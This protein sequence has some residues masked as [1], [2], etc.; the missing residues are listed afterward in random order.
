[1]V[2]G[3]PLV[4]QANAEDMVRCRS[5]RLINVGMTAAEVRG[6]CGEPKDI[7]VEEVPVRAQGAR[8]QSTVIVGVTRNERWTIDRG[9]G[10]FAAV[11]SFESDKLVRID[12]L[13]SR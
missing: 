3:G 12:L 8:G 4:P 9:Q 11:L 2:L 5:G 1:M 7:V 6:R 10:Q 13:T